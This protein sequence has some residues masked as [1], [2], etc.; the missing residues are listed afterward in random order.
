MTV[1]KAD[2]GK[3][4]VIYAFR[5]G[6]DV[7]FQ[8]PGSEISFPNGFTGPKSFIVDGVH[9]ETL[10][11]ELKSFMGSTK[12]VSDLD[13]LRKHREYEVEYIKKSSSPLTTFEE[14]GPRERP[15]ANGQPKFTFYLWRMLNPKEPEGTSQ[16]FLT[17]VS[18]NEV[19]VLSAIVRSSS[20]DQVAMQVFQSY[21]G[22]FQHILK[23][24]QCPEGKK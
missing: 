10:F 7:A 18:N 11:A 9:F 19:A 12:N 23:K 2:T 16:F 15:A 1:V 13:I 8:I 4:F 14:L 21:A 17:T 22:T 3:Q 6:P 5:E 24:D 20:Y